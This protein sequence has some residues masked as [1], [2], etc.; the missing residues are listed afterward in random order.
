MLYHVSESADITVFEP[1][2]SDAQ[3]AAI[4]WAVH[5]RRLHNYLLPRDCPRVCYTVSEQTTPADA[6]Q[7][8]GTSQ[9]V[10]AVES[11]WVQRMQSTTLYLYQLP[12]AT[13]RESDEGAGYFV[14]EQRVVPAAVTRIDNP[15]SAILERGVELRLM[16][17]LVAFGD[18]VVASTLQFSLIRM[19]NARR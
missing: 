2:W 11:E 7:F 13:F 12:A 18:R 4:V 15:I 10:V 1:R 6:E 17:D 19:R 14:S 8:L 16:R 5:E 9:A 3:G